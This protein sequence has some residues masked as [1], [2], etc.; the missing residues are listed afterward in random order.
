MSGKG[1]IVVEKSENEVEWYSTLKTNAGVI[2]IAVLFVIIASIV[3]CKRDAFTSPDGVVAGKASRMGT[4]SDTE[5]DRTW[6]SAELEKSVA[7]INR[8]AGN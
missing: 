8:R 3:Y 6:N 2:V 5:I 4:R 1:T 7:L